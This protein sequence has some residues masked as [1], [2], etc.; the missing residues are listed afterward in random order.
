MWPLLQEQEQLLAAYDE[1]NRDAAHQVK[2][3]QARLREREAAMHE[4]RRALE[5][6][7]V[8]AVEAQQDKNADTAQKLRCAPLATDSAGGNFL[9]CLRLGCSSMNAP[10]RSQSY[11][12]RRSLLLDM[13]ALRVTAHCP[14][15][16]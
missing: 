14:G 3:L 16:R 5:R 2:A 9:V 15:A 8:R 6:D 10:T 12:V 13:G 1:A 11:S 7:V 4:E